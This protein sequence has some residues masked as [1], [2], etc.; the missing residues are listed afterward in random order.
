MR[1]GFGENRAG[2]PAGANEVVRGVER[3]G[4]G[5]GGW[6]EAGEEG[7]VQL[8]V[9]PVLI[10]GAEGVG[11][12]G[13]CDADFE[14]AGGDEGRGDAGGDFVARGVGRGEG[15]LDAWIRR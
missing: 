1:R 6:A 2:R 3:A 11:G 9:R 4:E 5:G 7:G 10:V 15:R 8:G 13:E 14:A 12:V